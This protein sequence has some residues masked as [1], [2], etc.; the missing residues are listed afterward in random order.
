M[1]TISLQSNSND[2]IGMFRCVNKL[3]L[4]LEHRIDPHL[5]RCGESS[6]ARSPIVVKLE[7]VMYKN[8]SLLQPFNDSVPSSLMLFPLKR[9]RTRLEHDMNA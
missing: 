3:I 4:L 5:R 1:F 2:I 8:E 7:L 6:N 9:I